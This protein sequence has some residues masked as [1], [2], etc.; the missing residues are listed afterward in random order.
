MKNKTFTDLG[1]KCG[2][3]IHQQLLTERKLFCN[4]PAGYRND[5]PDA[6]IIRSM[7]PTLSELGEY[8]GTAL[9]EFKTKKK[10]IYQLYRD[11]M[12]TYEMDDTPPFL[13]NRQ[14]LDIAIQLAL[15]L[16]CSI[17]DEL[18]VARKQYL[19]GSIPTGFQRTAIV[20]VGGWVP[21]KGRKIRISHT[22]LEEDA[23][24]EVSDEGHVITWR[25]DRLSMPLIEVI[26]EPD[27]INPDEAREV[28]AL[29]G[30]VLKSS[31]LVRRGIGSVRQDV[32]VSITGGTRVEMK[33]ILKTG[34]V[35]KMTA[36]EALRQRCLLDIKDELKKR[37]LKKESFEVAKKDMTTVLANSTLSSFINKN[38]D[39]GKHI[40]AVKLPG[41]YGLMSKE[42][43][44]GRTFADEFS[45]RVR[46][47]ACL[48][49]LPNLAVSDIP[50]LEIDK[51]VWNKIQKDMGCSDNDVVVLIWGP[52]DDIITAMNEIEI[53]AIDAFDGVPNET[54]QHL[55]DY[56]T[57]FERILPGADRMYPDTDSP[58]VEIPACT[59]EGFQRL[60][61]KRSYEFEEKW[62]SLGVESTIASRVV[63]SSFK[64]MF[65]HLV[66][67]HLTNPTRLYMILMKASKRNDKLEK[68]DF[69]EV[70]A[71]FDSDIGLS[72]TG[73]EI[74]NLLAESARDT[75]KE[76]FE[77]LLDSKRSVS[78]EEIERAVEEVISGQDGDNY[79]SDDDKLNYLIGKVMA[80]FN[81]SVDG[82]M[83][84][85]LVKAKI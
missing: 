17:V 45:G 82:A 83:I 67:M 60:Q 62:E 37:G 42:I 66:E 16:N 20:G 81:S 1:F 11:N 21:Y 35:D 9:M 71:I 10:V 43:Q 70:A 68:L 24:R 77:K 29:I 7:R 40:G 69:D 39:K 46:V 32:N 73:E 59:V 19:D 51:S 27:M 47:I 80:K 41:F 12:C 6:E 72:I 49:A 74:V 55:K 76:N 58:P 52:E 3:E 85:E 5:K 23:C 31:G 34:Y 38:I 22:C 14:A 18:H 56:T 2:L 75:L 8:D 50:S 28:N 53:R 48:D 30:R 78:E 57:T 25:T 15:L 65:D 36:I 64:N 44:P 26:T 79:R 61:P 33:G 54:R 4:C 84:K 63:V 13:V